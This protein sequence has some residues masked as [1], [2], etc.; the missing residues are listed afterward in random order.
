MGVAL[1]RVR[2]TASAG[3]AAVARSLLEL[4]F[5]QI[6]L[7]IRRLERDLCRRSGGVDVLVYVCWTRLPPDDSRAGSI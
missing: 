1:V 2:S 3:D 6:R 5:P 4:C 7:R